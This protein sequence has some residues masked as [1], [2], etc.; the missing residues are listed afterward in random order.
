MVRPWAFSRLRVVG[1]AAG[2]LSCLHM[3]PKR[4]IASPLLCQ[5]GYCCVAADDILC[6][7]R[8]T[9]PLSASRDRRLSA[10]SV[11]PGHNAGDWH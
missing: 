11:Y 2:A 8:S 1:S 10:I 5:V 6:A 9:L 7:I 3:T 4:P